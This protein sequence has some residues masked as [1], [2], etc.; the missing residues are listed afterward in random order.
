MTQIRVELPEALTTVPVKAFLTQKEG[1][2]STLWKRIKHSGTFRVNGIPA[3]AALT[4]VK[5]GDILSFDIVRPSNIEPENLPLDIRYEDDYLMVVNKPAG[6]LVHPTTKEAHGTLGNAVLYWYEK[7]GEHH[8]YHPVHRLDRDTSGLVLIAK[9]PQVQYKLTPKRGEGKL[10]HRE[11]VA[12]IEGKLTP[13]SGLIDA[14]I[15][16]ALPSIILRKVAPD[17]QEART[18]YETVRTNGCFS[19]VRLVLDTG[20]THQ[21]R[22]HL[23]HLGHPLLGDDLYGGSCTLIKR[24]ALHACRLYFTHPLT[25]QTIDIKVPL[26]SDMEQIVSD[27]RL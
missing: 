5:N 18:H 11:Y 21:I 16:R 2:S 14:P 12:I 13:A 25:G 7:H 4:K 3:N 20:R 26:P 10:F 9:V 24:Q 23:A 22:V 1:I 15:A 27:C 6:Q 17:G 8:A 19:L